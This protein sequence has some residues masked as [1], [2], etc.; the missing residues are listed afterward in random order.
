ML[1]QLQTLSWNLKRLW[2]FFLGPLS[3]WAV[4]R[5]QLPC[6]NSHQFWLQAFLVEELATHLH[7][8]LVLGLNLPLVH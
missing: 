1:A 8:P 3:F 2:A 6:L 4:L 5:V 7:Q